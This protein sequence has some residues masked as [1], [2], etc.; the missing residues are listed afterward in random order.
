[1]RKKLS[2][3]IIVLALLLSAVTPIFAQQLS[4]VDTYRTTGQ[5]MV[6]KAPKPSFTNV[7]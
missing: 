7:L 2:M 5:F 4:T 3:F 6:N 1:M